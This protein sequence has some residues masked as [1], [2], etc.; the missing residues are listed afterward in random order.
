MES[1][2]HKQLVVTKNHARQTKQPELI[3]VVEELTA[4]ATTITTQ[5]VHFEYGWKMKT[6]LGLRWPDLLA[7]RWLRVLAW[8]AS[9]VS[10]DWL[11]FVV[12]NIRAWP[13][14]R[15]QVHCDCEW[16]CLGVY[17]KRGDRLDCKTVFRK[18]KCWESCWSCRERVLFAM[19]KGRGR[20]CWRHY[21][22][23][24]VPW[25]KAWSA[26]TVWGFTTDRKTARGVYRPEV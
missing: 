5:S 14:Q 4:F 26:R 10:F 17:L 23:H 15:W 18:Q 2:R 11:I 7:M 13:L 25:R 21:L 20:N 3:S 6:Y 22:Y 16:W 9:L 1:L 8:F 19:E 12:R 24:C